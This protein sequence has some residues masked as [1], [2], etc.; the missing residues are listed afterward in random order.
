MTISPGRPG[1]TKKWPC[2]FDLGFRDLAS[3]HTGVGY[4]IYTLYICLKIM[5]KVRRYVNNSP[6]QPGH[7]KLCPKINSLYSLEIAAIYKVCYF[8]KFHKIILLITIIRSKLSFVYTHAIDYTFGPINSAD[9]F[10]LH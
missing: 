5:D 4:F 10:V 8:V 1:Q 7:N 9:C 2:I 6:I 3:S